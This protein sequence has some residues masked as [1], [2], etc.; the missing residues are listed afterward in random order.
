ME[1]SRRGPDINDFDSIRIGLASS[2]QIRDWS[3]GEVTKPETINYR[4]LKPERDGLFCERIF[5]PTKDWECYCGK[6]KRVRYKGIICERCGVEVTRQKVRRERMGHIDLAAPVSHIWFFK[7]VPSRIGYLLDIAPRELEKVL[8]FA[9]SIVTSVDREQ[10]QKDL[11]DLEDKVAGESERVYLDRDEALAALDDRLARRRDFFASGKVRNFDEDDDFWARGLSNWA[12]E[13]GLPPLED[14]RALGAGVFV[15]LAKSI[16]S[17]DPRRVRELVRQAA[18]RDDRRLAPREVESVAAAAVQIETALA[19]LRAKLEKASGAKKG[20]ITKHVNKLVGD[21]LGGG[22]LSEEDAKLAADVD[23][24]NLERARDVG[25]GLLAD[26]LTAIAAIDADAD[27][28]AVREL[29]YDLCLVEGTRKEDLD[30]IGQ[31]ALKVREMVADI[32]VRREDTREAAVDAVRRLEQTWLLFKELEPKMIVGDEQI[33]RE[34]KDRF[35]SPY[36]F[37]VY[38]RG[39]MGAEAVRDLLRDLDLQDESL[40]LRD[41]IKTSKGQK[42][43]RAIK[44]LKVVEAF[45]QSG[46]K[47][48]WMILE[49]VPVI[50]P[51]LRPMVQLDGGRF[52]TSDLNDL[53]R[54]VI[55]RNNRLKRLLD[56]GAP[57]I[58]VNNEKRML[59]EAVDALFDNGRRGRAVTGPGN[60]PL[61]SLSDM[62]K[63]KQGRFRQN[64]LGKRVDYSGRSVIVAGPNL[65]LHQCGLPKLMAL[66]LFKPFIMSRLVERKAVQNIKAAK[67]MVES[68]IPEVWDVLEEVIAEHPVLLNRAPT[69]HRLG[70]QAF[71]PV[72]VEG[73]AIQVHPLVCQAFNADFDGDQ[74]AVHLPLSAEA[75]AEAR[76]LMLSSNNILSPAS[77][78]PLATPSQDMVLGAYF[79][80]YCEYDLT[81]MTAEE[82][83]KAIGQPGLKRFRVEEDVEQ[84]LEAGSV[85]Y[86]DPIEYT[87]SGE[88]LV[89]TPGRVIFNADVELALDEAT[90]G[91]FEDHPFL[92]RTLT[93]R[94]LDTFIGDLVEHYGPNTIAAALDVIKS[95]TFRFATRAGITISKNDIVIPEDKETILAGYEEEVAKVGLEYDRGLMTEEERNERVIAIWTRATDEVAERMMA[96]L[97]PTNPIYMMANSGARGSFNQIR[98][99]A[100]MRGL[101]AD[102]KGE[103]IARPIKANFMEGLTVLE[104]FISTHGARKGLADTALRTADS[105]YLTRR[106]V[107]VSQDVIVRDEDCGTEEHIQ[108]PLIVDG[109]PNKSV[110]GRVAALDI[111]KPLK[112]GKPGKTVLAEKGQEITMSTL[113]QLVEEFGEHAETATVPLRSVLKC[114]SEFGLCRKCY[115]TFLATGGMAEIGDAVGI[116]AAQS[117]GEPGTQ[118]TMRT[119]HTGGVAGADITHGLPRVVE[120]F[121]ARNPKGAATLAEVAGKIDIEEA[122]RT[123]KVTVTPTALDASGELQDPKEYSFPRRTRFLVSKGDV[124]EPGD[125]LNDGSL[126]P[127]DLLMLKGATPTELYLVGEVQKV[128]KS[129]GVE[130]HDKH[131]ELIVRQMLKKVRVESAGETTLLPGQLVDRVVL[132]RENAR[133]KKEKGEQAT[134]EPIILG[135][136]KASLATESFLSAASFQET[137]KVLTDAAIEGK[138]DRLNGLKEN[139]IIGKLIPAATGLKQYRQITIEPTEPLPV[140]F[141]RPEAEAELLAA[142]EEIG[143][144]EGFDFDALDISLEDEAPLDVDGEA[145]GLEPPADED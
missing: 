30:S 60:R 89:T 44:R 39:G 53:Y 14:V 28:S 8:Y 58:I 116:I 49:A 57:E 47:P 134:F 26:V 104:Y 80:T 35:G 99:L 79:L 82:V 25:E 140:T 124:V 141:A 16:T 123:I 65:K 56:L 137:T 74:M 136:T 88:R 132:E 83:A 41:V 119:F 6:Y 84:A 113:R 34:L 126:N 55:N 130:I 42:Q 108:A 4:T 37:G 96:N 9:A 87:W 21:L 68:M 1:T 51:E 75:Q 125:P 77:G 128:Y 46:N 29:A 64:L 19:P 145:A 107:D 45:I 133:V 144:G 129:Q 13:S 106:L 73:K 71:E 54:R 143:E 62:L 117:I 59:Q 94:E 112:D 142:L 33:F 20:A 120:I 93:K 111:N 101:M 100:G 135:I 98:Q 138:V 67:K 23:A 121:E 3:S 2:K 76:V 69:L 72:L 7:G 102:P 40:T 139:V 61:K 92:N 11:A 12:E 17:E 86:Q 22:E 32:E 27:A 118:L 91:D 78:R 15:K 97:E 5:G 85:G 18:T 31:W 90:G 52:A 10:R 110:A 109:T 66:E 24:K 48:E 81:S 122:E 95:V 131:I 103:I 127:A 38:F 70:I 105:G 36:G 50:P 43:Q 115:G 114:R 63:G